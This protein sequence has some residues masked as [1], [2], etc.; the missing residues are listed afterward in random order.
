M[1]TSSMTT[2]EAEAYRKGLADGIA[3]AKEMTAAQAKYEAERAAVRRAT[4]AAY[5]AAGKKA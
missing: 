5:Q 4:L 2:G 3:K 1:N